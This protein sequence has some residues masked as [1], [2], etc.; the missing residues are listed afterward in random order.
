LPCPC[1]RAL[2]FFGTS[3]IDDAPALLDRCNDIW[4]IAAPA[5]GAMLGDH[6][7]S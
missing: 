5:C 4:R 3:V 1:D 2:A 6:A 7:R